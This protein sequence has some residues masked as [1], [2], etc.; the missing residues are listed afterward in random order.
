ML[1]MLH[2]ICMLLSLVPSQV[3]L[4]TV[5]ELAIVPFVSGQ[6]NNLELALSLAKR[7][8]LPGAENL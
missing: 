6:L 3:L 7:G 5:N 4:A 2:Q 1:E 8:N